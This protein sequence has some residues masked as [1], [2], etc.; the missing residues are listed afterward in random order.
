MIWLFTFASFLIVS[1]IAIVTLKFFLQASI[2]QQDFVSENK[3]VESKI[4][5]EVRELA[6]F[7]NSLD[8][9][10]PIHT[11]ADKSATSSDALNIGE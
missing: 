11:A 5:K 6:D 3:K 2:Y 8:K 9:K 1:V 7:Y 10:L 4:E